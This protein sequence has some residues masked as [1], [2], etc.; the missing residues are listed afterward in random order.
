MAL[1]FSERKKI[2]K[3]VCWRTQLPGEACSWN[4]GELDS[5]I[6]LYDLGPR[7]D[8]RAMSLRNV[9]ASENWPQQ[10]WKWL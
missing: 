2:T 4:A 10:S 6:A 1:M 5:R 3:I 7:K 8:K 9:E